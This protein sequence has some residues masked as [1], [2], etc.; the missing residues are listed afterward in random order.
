MS[1]N[2]ENNRNLVDKANEA[3]NVEFLGPSISYNREDFNTIIEYYSIAT[4]PNDLKKWSFQLVKKNMKKFYENSNMGWNSGNKVKEMREEGA[5]YLIA[6]Q[7]NKVHKDSGENQTIGKPIGF[8]MFQFTLEETMADDDQEIEAIY[9]YEIQLTSETRGK[10]LGK[11]LMNTMEA[12]GKH[13]GMKKSMLTTFKANTA[14]FNFYRKHLKYE[15]DE[16]SPSKV[17]K[18]KEAKK[19]D[20]EILSKVLQN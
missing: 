10:G 4:L 15:I 8:L 18:P 20:Y 13:W 16:I 12:I 2:L 14:A 19:Y 5:R 9:C 1:N 17:L 6:R 3:A 7:F 11:F